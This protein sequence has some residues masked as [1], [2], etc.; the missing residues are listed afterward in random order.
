MIPIVTAQKKSFFQ[1]FLSGVPYLALWIVSTLSSTLADFV[2]EKGV[3][4]KTVVRKIANSISTFGPALSLF[5]LYNVTIL[6]QLSVY[7]LLS[8]RL[9]CE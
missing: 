1:A 2:I 9:V 7:L 8:R 5:G 6:A 3:F 4:S